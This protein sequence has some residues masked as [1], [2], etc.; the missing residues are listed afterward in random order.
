[1]SIAEQFEDK[2]V[3]GKLVSPIPRWEIILKRILI[4]VLLSLFIVVGGISAG[5]LSWFLFDPSDLVLETG[6]LNLLGNFLEDLSLFWATISLVS[7]IVAIWIFTK[8]PRGYRFRVVAVV[9]SCV[10]AF[11]AIGAALAF[12]G[13]SDKIEGWAAKHIPPYRS[14]VQPKAQKM[15]KP[16]EGTILGRVLA[17]SSSSIMLADPSEKPWQVQIGS[18]TKLRAR[19]IQ[20][21]DCL[22]V[23]GNVA[24]STYNV[25][26]EAIG[27]CPRGVRLRLLRQTEI[28]TSTLRIIN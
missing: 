2:I 15:M 28:R 21:G 5:I 19:N 10:V 20:I 18:K 17:V 13:M 7:A 6:K 1:M 8:S 22:Q 4:W 11:L 27:F 16:Q 14:L 24:A 26:A 25:E 12:G 9:I 3:A 23:M